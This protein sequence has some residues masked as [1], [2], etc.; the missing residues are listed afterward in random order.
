MRGEHQTQTL[1]KRL[2]LLVRKYEQ[3]HHCGKQDHKEQCS[4]GDNGS[5][6]HCSSSASALA[7]LYGRNHAWRASFVELFD[8]HCRSGRQ[9]KFFGRGSLVENDRYKSVGIDDESEFIV[10]KISKC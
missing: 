1:P 7:E 5:W 2:E 4:D 9:T 3:L 8:G 6:S 10:F